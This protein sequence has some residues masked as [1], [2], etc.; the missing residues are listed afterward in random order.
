MWRSS[1][2]PICRIG[3]LTHRVSVDASM[4]SRCFDSPPTLGSERLPSGEPLDDVADRFR[5]APLRGR[6]VIPVGGMIIIS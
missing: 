2:F 6:V 3:D 5:E 4:C 1:T